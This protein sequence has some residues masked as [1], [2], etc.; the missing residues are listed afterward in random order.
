MAAPTLDVSNLSHDATGGGVLGT[1]AA[2]AIATGTAGSVLSND[3]TTA[4]HNGTYAAGDTFGGSFSFEG[5][6]V[7]LTGTTNDLASVNAAIQAANS[8]ALATTV[9][10]VDASGNLQL[11]DS[12]DPG[13]AQ[14]VDL[15]SLQTYAQ[16]SNIA[17]GGYT[18]AL[19][20]TDATA[21]FTN[22]TGS[23][24]TTSSSSVTAGQQST[25]YFSN[26]TAFSINDMPLSG[27]KSVNGSITATAGTS[28]AGTSLEFQI[29]ANEGQTVDLSI[30]S[31]AA[32]QLG[33]GASSYTD[34][35]GN[36]QTV[37]TNNVSDINVTTFKGAQDA[38]AVLDQAIS[39]VST[40]QANLGAFDANVLQSNEQSLGTATT[41]LQAA[42]ATITDADMA[43]T[44]VN[45]T[46]DSILVQ[47]ATSALA[48]ANQQPQSIL[49]LLQ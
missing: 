20:G 4:Y 46:K 18:A 31:T 28:T 6:T 19:Q 27:T 41:N 36:S 3:T 43:S 14:A 39:Q 49:K 32:N 12:A 8:G 11:S 24:V 23:T 47:A 40:V 44:V 34:S 33:V 1:D 37:L 35:N 22:S 29:G 2:V 10:S 17:S 45:E 16:G 15:S 13:S 38:I 48:F 21:S 5:T 30:G 26:G 25:F 42:H 9:A 7:A